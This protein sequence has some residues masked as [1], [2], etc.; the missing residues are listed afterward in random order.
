LFN[1]SHAYTKQSCLAI[2]IQPLIALFEGL[3]FPNTTALISQLSTAD[4]Q[5]EI[6]GI[7]QSLRALADSF[8]PLIA[9]FVVIAGPSIPTLISGCVIG[10]TAIIFMTGF[11]SRKLV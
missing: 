8:P 9:G 10:L 6:L 3:V 1:H 4:Q 11:R 2:L 5:G 7:T